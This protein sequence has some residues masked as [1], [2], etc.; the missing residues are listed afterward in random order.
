[1]RQLITGVILAASVIQLTGCAVVPW[2]KDP[3]VGFMV[4]GIKGDP[5]PYVMYERGR[6]KRVYSATAEWWAYWWWLPFVPVEGGMMGDHLFN[7]P[8]QWWDC[9]APYACPVRRPHPESVPIQ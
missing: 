6:E 1:M 4:G 3:G 7:H 8:V 9:L 2:G 5:T